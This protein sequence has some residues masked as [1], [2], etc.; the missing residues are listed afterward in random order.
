M[1]DQGGESACK[2]CKGTG[3][4]SLTPP[5]L[6]MES[7]VFCDDCDTGK[8]KWKEV[9]RLIDEIETR[10]LSTVFVPRRRP[11]P[12]SGQSPEGKPYR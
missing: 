7:G 6:P 9:T 2:R 11:E 3:T 12:E 8:Q 1:P 10:R 5:E 4:V